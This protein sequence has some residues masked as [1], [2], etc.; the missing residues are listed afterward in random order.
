MERSILVWIQ[1]VYCLTRRLLVVFV[2][3]VLSYFHVLFYVYLLVYYGLA[4]DVS[5]VK[6]LDL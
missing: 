4:I 6:A 1:L 3:Y 2:V 5:I